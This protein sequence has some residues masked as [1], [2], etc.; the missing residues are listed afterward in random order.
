MIG[1]LNR[2]HALLA[3]AMMLVVG[4]IYEASMPMP[5]APTKTTSA[6]PDA[7]EDGWTGKP[8]PDFLLSTLD[9]RR[10]RL[11]QFRG[12]TVL[13]NFWATWCTPCRVDMPWLAAFYERYRG[14]NFE[15]VGISMDD[16]DRDNVAEFVRETK[17]GYTVLLKDDTVGSAYGG[18]RFL[19]QSFFVGPD[20]RILAHTI[21]IRSKANIEADILAALHRGARPKSVGS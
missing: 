15:I 7:V 14:Q 3:G 11:S 21:G 20:G 17:V 2:R 10:L 16:G 19:P 13:L 1:K 6:A 9:G 18:A 4:V 8:A 5:R 12:K